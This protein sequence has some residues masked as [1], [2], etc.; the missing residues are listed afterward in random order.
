MIDIWGVMANGLWVLGLAL[1]LATL[2][3]AHWAASMERTRFRTILGRPGVQ[4][5]TNLALALFCLGLATT[6]RKWWERA[7]WGLLTVA[8]VVQA[9]TAGR[10][11]GTADQDVS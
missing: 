11:P 5:T 9:W 2:S 10:K 1:L 4:R 6:A 3:W 7:V 8:W